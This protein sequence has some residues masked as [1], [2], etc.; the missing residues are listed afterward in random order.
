[1]TERARIGKFALLSMT[2]AAVFNFR[3]VVNNN[4]EIGMVSATGF[5]F[6]TLFYFTPFVFII[7]EFV[8]L[9][10][11]SESGVYQWVKSSLGPK[12]AFLAAYTYWFVN[13]FYFTSFYC[14]TVY[15]FMLHI[16]SLDM[17]MYFHQQ[18]FRFYR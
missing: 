3:N 11:D 2:I 13:L 5:L 7:A 9:N 17:N 8:S 18:Q 16:H 14:P 12:W 1:M 15:W 6:A 4:I 10:K